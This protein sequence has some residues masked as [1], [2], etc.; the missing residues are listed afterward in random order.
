MR[1]RVVL[2]GVVL[3][4]MGARGSLAQTDLVANLVGFQ[5]P[6]GNIHCMAGTEGKNAFLRC[7]VLNST[8]PIP[9]RP[10]D[11]ELDYGTAFGMNTTGKSSRLCVGDTVADPKNPVLKYN[12]TWLKHGFTCVSRTTG[13]R[14][15][16]R[17]L[18]GFEL[19][20]AK[21]T[22]F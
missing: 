5:T 21:Q 8:A 3:V 14:C 6:S 1:T 2:A 15:V 13:L 19:S 4:L 10:R 20:R 11:C 9:S 17:D 22:L 18:R 16:N 7:D 12:T